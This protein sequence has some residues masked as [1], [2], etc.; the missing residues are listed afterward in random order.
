MIESSLILLLKKF[1][2]QQ[3]KDFNNFVKSPFFNT[4]SALVKLYEYIRKQYPDYNPEKLEKEFVYKKLFG[5]TEYN[6]GFLRV[7]MSNLQSLAEEYL[8][9]NR[10]QAD[11]LIK[12]KYL[13]D[14]LSGIGARKQAEKVL[15][16][17][18]KEISKLSP[19]NPD[20]YLGMYHMA[21]YKR[22]FYSTQFVVN[23]SNKPDESIFDEQKYFIM[24]FLLRTLAGHFYHL[25]QMQIISYEPKLIFLDEITLF[26]E[27][28]PGYLEV[29]MLNITFLRLLLLKN[30]DIKD[31]YRLKES[32]YRTFEKLDIKDA[33]NTIS[34]ILNYCQRNY[35]QTDDELFQLEKF[36]ILK[37]AIKNDLNT[38][39]KSEGMDGSRF[40]NIVSTALDF[41]ETGWA[42]DFIKNFGNK[43]DPD[44]KDYLIAFAD[45]MVLSSRKE[46]DEALE[47]LSK[48]RNPASSND[49]FNLKV[50]QMKIYF[51]MDF[52]DQAESSA[53]SFRHMIQN[54]NVLPEA[55]KELHKNFYNFYMKLL[56]IKLKHDR[57][58]L[59]ELLGKL[60]SVRNVIQKK[61]IAE[62]VNEIEN[63]MNVS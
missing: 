34:V 44:K 3:L 21:F 58:L 22:Y 19:Q 32:F 4:N 28:N 8:T 51:E 9:Y 62:K 38:F 24:H 47:R 26:L 25:N 31:Y 6:D 40:H 35:S 12:K 42:E 55:Y 7:L 33:F 2:K 52:I 14:A 54:D 63:E 20:D 48:L 45:A 13:L 36:D 56:S 11:T 59:I 5:K 10:F 27:R 53:D 39:E 30:N 29:P 43:L 41:K 15:N 50:L 46:N 18:L 17:G 60:N 49:K 23:K 37:F 1:D 57:T 61:W 16:E